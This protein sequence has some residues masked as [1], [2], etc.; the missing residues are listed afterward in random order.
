MKNPHMIGIAGL[1]ALSACAWGQTGI[2]DKPASSMK[3]PSDPGLR[4]APGS[5]MKAPSNSGV[6]VVP[7]KTDPEAIA[8]PPKNVDPG[9]D[10]ATGR[11]DEK[12]RKK[13]QD[14]KNAH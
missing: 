14:K 1:F 8:T 4:G 11:I 7:P 5:S 10:D 2:P 9:M 12:N 3:T 6:V 13:S